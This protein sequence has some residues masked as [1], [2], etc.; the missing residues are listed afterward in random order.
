LQP[1]EQTTVLAAGTTEPPLPVFVITGTSGE[2]KSTLAKLLLERMP[3]LELAV[4][5]TTRERRPGEVDG[6]HYWF[7]PEEEFSRRLEAGELLEYVEFPWGQ[8]S[9]TLW[10]E[11]DRIQ[12]KGR[13]P[14]LELEPGGA[15]AVRDRVPGAVTIFVTAPSRE[16]LERRLRARATESA[17]EIEER[18]ELAWRQRSLAPEFTY[19]LVNDDLERAIA[20]LEAIVRRHLQTA[21]TISEL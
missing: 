18:L 10:S 12:G 21:G 4:S 1:A 9:G 3:E 17:G 8:R 14:L 15:L 2:G 16:E 7:I 20:E 11:I 13:V 5:A 6:Q 19:K